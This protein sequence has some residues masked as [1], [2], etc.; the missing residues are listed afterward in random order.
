MK[1][2]VLLVAEDDPNDAWLLERALDRSGS[3]FHM[4]RVASGEELI[5][6]VGGSGA[7]SDRHLYP[8]PDLVLLDLKMPLK[9]GFAVLQWRLDTPGG[10]RMPFVVLSSSDLREDIDRAYALGA[11]SYV[12]KPIGGER[13]EAMV[14][15]LNGWWTNFNLTGSPAFA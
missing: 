6:Y 14:K 15:A 2:Q 5:D 11:N 4:V 3:A 1:K 10:R 12:Q 9:D 13:L 7:F 8:L